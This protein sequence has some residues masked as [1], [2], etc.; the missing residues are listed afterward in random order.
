MTDI[1]AHNGHKVIERWDNV[2]RAVS[3]EPRRQL[4]VSLLDASDGDPVPL[5]ESAV[6]PNVPVDADRLRQTLYHRHLPL[7]AEMRFVEWETGPLVAS[8]GPRF[9]EVAII[10]EAL[11]ETATG[12]PDSLVIGCQRLEEEQQRNYTGRG[13]P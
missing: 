2:F 10:F 9:E 13:N 6:N 12:I 3:A 7:L 5:P 1:R 11:Y 8:R 4:I